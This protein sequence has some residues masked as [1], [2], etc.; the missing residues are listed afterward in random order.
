VLL[1]HR[2]R[3]RDR[4]GEQLTPLE[5]PAVTVTWPK[6]NRSFGVVDALG[7]TGL[8]GLLVA[9]F[10][11]IARIIPG[12]GCILRSHFGWPCPGCGLTR[13]ADHMSH[14]HFAAA[15]D[16][17]PLGTVA[18]GLFMV[19]IAWGFLHLAFKVPVPDVRLS[20]REARFGRVLLV[21]LVVV[22]YAWVV[23]KFRHPEWVGAA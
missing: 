19:A 5:S 8:A 14:F 6:P 21:V 9:R 10:I 18:A 16:A 1:L 7:I 3:D 22:N 2:R 15:W 23:I 13:V 11:P 12:W 4:S 17:N 20:D